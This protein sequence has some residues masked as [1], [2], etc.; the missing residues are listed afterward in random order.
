MFIYTITANP[1]HTND[2]TGMFAGTLEEAKDHFAYKAHRYEW[3]L[4]EFTT[5]GL[6]A[7]DL[8]EGETTPELTEDNIRKFVSTIWDIPERHINLHKTNMTV[9]EIIKLSSHNDETGEYHKFTDELIQ[10]VVIAAVSSLAA[11]A[12]S[13][14]DGDVDM[15][16][17]L[18]STDWVMNAQPGDFAI[19]IDD[20]KTE[21]MVEYLSGKSNI[22]HVDAKSIIGEAAVN[23]IIDAYKNL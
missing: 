20:G 8:E 9:Q 17:Q 22:A 12:T 6:N 3:N 1:N 7:E 21:I 23:K 14:I 2:R 19:T 4:G 11:I 15:A 18:E 5:W 13:V 10:D 16:E